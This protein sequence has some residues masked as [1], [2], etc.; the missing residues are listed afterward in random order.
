[1]ITS[2]ATIESVTVSLNGTMIGCTDRLGD[3]YTY[4]NINLSG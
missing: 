3:S 1:M 4:L 2:T